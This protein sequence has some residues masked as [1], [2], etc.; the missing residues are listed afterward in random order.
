MRRIRM[1]LMG[2]ALL[3]AVPTLVT[4]PASA[5]DPAPAESDAHKADADNTDRNDRDRD[6]NTLTPMDQGESEA[7]VSITREIRK[8]L[9]AD[10]ALSMNAQNVKVITREGVVT[11]RGPVESA[12]EKARVGALAS[13]AP[14]VRDVENHIEIK[15]Q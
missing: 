1:A 3:S 7:D 14:G 4:L 15:T 12:E 11:L 9:V 13:K 5:A 2:G 10:D 6:G 8:A